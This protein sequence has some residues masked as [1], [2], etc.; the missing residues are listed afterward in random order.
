MA[1]Q[2]AFLSSRRRPGSI[3]SRG[4]IEKETYYVYIV[5]SKRY[6]TLY[7][8]STSDL[9]KRIWEHK[10]KVAD[11]F[12]KKHNVDQLVYYERHETP[13]SMVKRE[14]NMKDWQRQW[15]INLIEENNPNWYD[16][17]PDLLQKVNV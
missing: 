7:I 12:T 8:G 16:L 4:L 15:K 6:G 13:E 2:L 5:A 1:N 11:G 3:G 14:R 10:N 9:V 17:Y